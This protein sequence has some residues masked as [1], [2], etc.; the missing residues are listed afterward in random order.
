MNMESIIATAPG[1][2]AWCA[3][4]LNTGEVLSYRDREV[5]PSASLIKVPILA[6]LFRRV[7]EEG[8]SLDETLLLRKEDQVPGSGVMQD[9]T[10]GTRFLLRDLAMLMIT[11]SDNSATNLL[12]DFLTVSAVNGLIRRLGLTH[13]VLERRLQRIPVAREQINRTSAYDMTRLMELLAQGRVI[14][15][16]VSRRMIDML[17]RCQAPQVLAPQIPEPEYLE[18]PPRIQVAHKTGSLSQARHDS[19]IV[20]TARNQVLAITILSQGAPEPTLQK[21]LNRIGQKLYHQIS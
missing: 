7:E 1:T 17:S 5:Y 9:L 13:T 21:Y 4:N 19:G 8:L 16:D 2:Y 11:V 6:E 10:P 3:K 20:Y 15:F 12:I 14:S 18:Q